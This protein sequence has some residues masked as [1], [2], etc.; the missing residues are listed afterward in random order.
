[1]DADVV[2]VTDDI[3]AD[4]T[5]NVSQ[6]FVEGKPEWDGESDR[7]YSQINAGGRK[8]QHA[9]AEQVGATNDAGE[10]E[11]VINSHSEEGA[12]LDEIKLGRPVKYVPNDNTLDPQSGNP[13]RAD[14]GS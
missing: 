10:L 4:G 6:G 2:Y 5:P 7:D 1:M 14:G 3:K 8:W 11:P 13:R 12:R 9:P